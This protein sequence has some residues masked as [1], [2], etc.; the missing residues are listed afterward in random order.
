MT[1]LDPNT[2]IGVSF[3][4]SLMLWLIGIHCEAM[5]LRGEI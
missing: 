2:I 1:L 3:W 5:V 4:V